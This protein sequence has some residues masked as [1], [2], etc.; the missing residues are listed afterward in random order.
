M[1]PMDPRRSSS[2]ILKHDAP[3][4]QKGV[5]LLVKVAM[6]LPVSVSQY[7]D[8]RPLQRPFKRAFQGTLSDGALDVLVVGYTVEAPAVLR[9]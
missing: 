6:I 7:L 8:S 3:G 1:V 2:L 9:P 5:F 4:T